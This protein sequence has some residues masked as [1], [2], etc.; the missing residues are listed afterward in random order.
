MQCDVVFADETKLNISEIQQGKDAL[1]KRYFIIL[2][3][4]RLATS[5]S[6]DKISLHKH[7]NNLYTYFDIYIIRLRYLSNL[8]S[9]P[10]SITLEGLSVATKRQY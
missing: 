2:Q 1:Q 4:L 3:Y 8:L 5:K 10:F 6:S 7:Y 9:S